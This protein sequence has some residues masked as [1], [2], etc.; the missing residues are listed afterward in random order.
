MTLWIHTL[1]D[2]NMSTESDDHSLMHELSDQLDELCEKLG[3]EKLSSFFDTTDLELNLAEDDDSE[4]WEEPEED[5]ETG[6]SYGIDDMRWF[7][8]A[9]GLASLQA[10]RAHLADSADPAL[11]EDS[12]TLLLEE[13]DDCIERLRGPATRGGRFN[14]AVVM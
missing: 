7:D 5:P 13:L 6:Y 4:D 14:L 9:A 11:D 8:A 2:R 12:K 10:L 1:E 3:V